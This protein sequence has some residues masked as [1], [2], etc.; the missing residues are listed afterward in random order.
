MNSLQSSV[1]VPFRRYYQPPH[2]FRLL[3][4]GMLYGKH[5][6]RASCEKLRINPLKHCYSMTS[7]VLT[8]KTCAFCLWILFM[9]VIYLA[10]KRRLVISPS[11]A[12]TDLFNG[13]TRRALRGTISKFCICYLISSLSFKVLKSRHI[14]GSAE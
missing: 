9:D 8:S 12:T 10:K 2:L 6:F 1:H 5:K 14:T 3:L 13:E 7:L 11:R 4:Y